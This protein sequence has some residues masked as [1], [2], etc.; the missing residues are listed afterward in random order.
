[1]T[2]GMMLFSDTTSMWHTM[3]S[4]SAYWSCTGHGVSTV[5]QSVIASCSGQHVVISSPSAWSL[6]P[7]QQALVPCVFRVFGTKALLVPLL[8]VL[9]PY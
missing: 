3:V 8:L 1:M 7:P 6:V 4:G 2:A 9:M 5:M